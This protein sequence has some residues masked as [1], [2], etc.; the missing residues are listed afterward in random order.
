MATCY[1]YKQG[2][3]LGHP[4][5]TA[6]QYYKSFATS[7]CP[8]DENELKKTASI[9]SYIFDNMWQCNAAGLSIQSFSMS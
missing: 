2:E 7:L 1:F 3:I 5:I 4:N 8:R 6:L 9:T